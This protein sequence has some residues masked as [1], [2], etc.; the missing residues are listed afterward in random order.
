MTNQQQNNLL[1]GSYKITFNED[2][3]LSYTPTDETVE[4]KLMSALEEMAGLV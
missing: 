3:T 4:G 2:G 1:D